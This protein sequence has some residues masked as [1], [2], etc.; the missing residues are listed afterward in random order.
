MSA[1]NLGRKIIYQVPDKIRDLTAE[2]RWRVLG[3][4][5]QQAKTIADERLLS[6]AARQP[7]HFKFLNLFQV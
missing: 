2:Q 4:R 6:F 3:A 7:I 1:Q 5:A